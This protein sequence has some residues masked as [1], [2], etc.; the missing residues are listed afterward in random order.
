MHITS[1]FLTL[2]QR[3]SGYWKHFFDLLRTDIRLT[4]SYHPQSN[5]GSERFN[6]TL[7][8]ALRSFVNVRHDDW[9]EYLVHIEFAY[10]SSV[11]PAAFE[12]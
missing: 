1:H 9:D 2:L 7:I 6:R 11:N 4:S 5:G 3:C 10:N 12:L 8:E